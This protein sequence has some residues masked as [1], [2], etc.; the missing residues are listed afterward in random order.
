MDNVPKWRLDGGWEYLPIT[1]ALR[2]AGIE[3]IEVLFGR[4][5]NKVAQFLSICPIVELCLEAERHPGDRV[6]KCLWDQNGLFLWDHRGK[7]R[8]RRRVQRSWVGWGDGTTNPRVTR[9]RDNP[10][11]VI[12]NSI[13]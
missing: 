1:E 2:G 10:L 8:R 13:P 3:E 5:N 6:E 9:K 11:K 4:R 12:W 7:G